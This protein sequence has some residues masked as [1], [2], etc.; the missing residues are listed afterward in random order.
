MRQAFGVELPLRTLF[1][2]P[3]IAGL[4]LVIVQHLAAR[5][6][7]VELAAIRAEIERPSGPAG[8]RSLP[9]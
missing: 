4:A 7:P 8:E 1:E 3:T 6:D 9:N 2:S 5:A